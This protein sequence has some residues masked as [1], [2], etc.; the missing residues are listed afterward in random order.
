MVYHLFA[1]RIL[2]SLGTKDILF[3]PEY[4]AIGTLW[5]LN[6]PKC[7]LQPPVWNKNNRK[8]ARLMQSGHVFGVFC[9]QYS[10]PYVYQRICLAV[11]QNYCQEPVVKIGKFVGKKKR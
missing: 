5:H 2:S 3:V 10:T 11:E 7:H 6:V 9:A 4:A 1:A 8:C